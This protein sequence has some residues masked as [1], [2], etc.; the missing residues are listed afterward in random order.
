MATDD[1]QFDRAEST[2]PDQPPLGCTACKR[3]IADTYYTANGATV[4][5]GCRRQLEREMTAPNRQWPLA[6]LLG[7]GAAILGA[8]LYFAVTA[9][10]GYEIGLVA[11][12][13][14]WLV[15]RAIQKGTGGRGGR[16]YQVAAVLLTYLSVAGAYSGLAVREMI[17]R[18]S[19]DTL[20]VAPTPDPD[21]ATGA[22]QT[23]PN[24]PTGDSVVAIT[25]SA[26]AEQD[27]DPTG[28]DD[29]SQPAGNA[30]L[31]LA[32]LMLGLPI[33]SALG[34]L[35]GGLISLLILGIG[36]HQAWRMTGKLSIDLHGPFQVRQPG[37]PA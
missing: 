22:E 5:D 28:T 31:T 24:S 14:G 20:E 3:P 4:C 8:I 18:A 35:P 36:L 19:T 15:G 32:G 12:A 17:G 34:A 9:I 37:S 2:A 11:I 6:I 16:G 1:L 10:T 30:W 26:S 13:V 33:I 29:P 27:G 7:V 23:S 25:P 21:G